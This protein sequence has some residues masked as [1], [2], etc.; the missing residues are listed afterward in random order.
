MYE[1][2]VDLLWSKVYTRLPH[3]DDVLSR[4]ALVQ[5]ELQGCAVGEGQCADADL[6]IVHLQILD[7][8]HKELENISEALLADTA[9]NIEC[10]YDVGR[11]RAI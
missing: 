7:H 1:P 3:L 10:D 11:S 9:R 6:V 4:A 5:A 8:A 2:S